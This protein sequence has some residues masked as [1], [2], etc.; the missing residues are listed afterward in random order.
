MPSPI[1]HRR[2]GKI[3]RLPNI[4]RSSLNQMILDGLP[5]RKIIEQLGEHGQGLNQQNLTNW[6][7]GGHQDWLDQQDRLDDMRDK[8]EFAK[9]VVRE[10]AGGELQEASIHIAAAQIYQVLMDYDLRA[11]KKSLKADP[12]NYARVINALSKLGEG[13][14]KFDRYRAEVAQHKANIL[15]ELANSEPGGF[16][17]ETRRR[18]ENE[19]HLM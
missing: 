16:T 6:K 17:P 1:P 18:V 15:K 9:A 5:Y 10:N 12:E 3:A 14:L 11:L 2:K 4:V 7:K 8:R 19:L 13:S